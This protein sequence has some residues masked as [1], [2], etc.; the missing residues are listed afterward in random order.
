MT[1][2][3]EPCLKS[4]MRMGSKFGLEFSASGKSVIVSKTT[5]EVEQLS[6][7]QT[8]G[9][10]MKRLLASHITHIA[11]VDVCDGQEAVVWQPHSV[12]LAEGS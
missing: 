9:G 2:Q 1:Q 6:F 10:S 7:N 4:H 12:R 8:F 3:L 11:H 5:S